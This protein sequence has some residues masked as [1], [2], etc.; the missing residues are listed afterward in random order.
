M[1]WLH[2]L[3]LSPA[4]VVSEAELA[5]KPKGCTKCPY[6]T[7]E[8]AGAKPSKR[9]RSSYEDTGTAAAGMQRIQTKAISAMVLIELCTCSG[10]CVGC[11]GGRQNHAAAIG[12]GRKIRISVFLPQR[13]RAWPV[14]EVLLHVKCR[15]VSAGLV[16]SR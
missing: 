15:L 12:R 7:V 14:S 8:A 2:A 6:W 11:V 13:P 4:D 9:S 16:W 5:A 10:T 3:S 1:K